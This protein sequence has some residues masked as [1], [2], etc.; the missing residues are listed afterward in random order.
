MKNTR[1]FLLILAVLCV[2]VTLLS[3][4][5]AGGRRG[6]AESADRYLV[7]VT[8]EEGRPVPG[9]TV[10]F[11]SDTACM[12]E[13]TDKSG[14]AGFACGAGSYTV[15]ILGVPEGYAPDQTEY[16]APS[17]PGTVSVVLRKEKTEEDD[18]A[19]VDVPRL[20]VHYERPEKYGKLKGILSLRGGFPD[21]GLMIFSM[22]YYAV[23][24][25]RVDAYTEYC[26]AYIDAWLNGKELPQAPDPSWMSEREYAVLFTVFGIPDG[27]GEEELRALLRKCNAPYYDDFSRLEEIGSDGDARFYLGQYRLTES[28]MDEYREMMGD[29][30]PEF[31]DLYRDR[32]TF[33]SSLRLSMPI[34]PKDPEVGDVFRF[35][36]TDL[37]GNPVDSA[38][39][40]AGSRVTMI[41][42]WATWCGPCKR[43]L[44]ALAAMAGDLEARG[45]RVVGL[46]SDA[47]Q[48][49]RAETARALLKEAGA[50]YLNLAGSKRLDLIFHVTAFPTTFFFDSEGRLLLPPIVGARP[51]KYLDAAAEALSLAGGGNA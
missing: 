26:N 28:R 23:S 43:E 44:P 12:T 51:E 5:A 2:P 1:L 32:E 36:T 30:F 45:C 9:A 40:F 6:G 35:E 16:A 8:D 22:E 19:V 50:D 17:A 4:C 15:H 41:N 46:C 47:W 14:V 49:E 3:A 20:G 38:E 42:L 39:L 7:L 33:L 21:D 37:D 10:Q 11:C 29:F 13:E 31:D 48:E 18:E 25:E 27:G 24:P 34:W